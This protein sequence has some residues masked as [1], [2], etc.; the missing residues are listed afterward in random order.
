MRVIP[1][2]LTSFSIILLLSLIAMS[3]SFTNVE[4]VFADRGGIAATPY[5]LEEP[6]QYAVISWYGSVEVLYLTTVVNSPVSTKLIEVLP[7]PSVPKIELGTKKVF[8]GLGS[9][10][11][12]HMSLGVPRGSGVP[13]AGE[14]EIILQKVLG[15]HNITVIKAENYTGF[16]YSL[17]IIAEQNGF[18][19]LDATLEN[20]TLDYCIEDYISR[21][22]NIFAIDIVTIEA[23]D[24]TIAPLVYTF[25]SNKIYYPLKISAATYEGYFRVHLYFITASPLDLEE[26]LETLDIYGY[27][28]SSPSITVRRSKL[29]NLDN[30]L[31]KIFPPWIRFLSVEYVSFGGWYDSELSTMITDIVIDPPKSFDAIFFVVGAIIWAFIIV[32]TALLYRRQIPL[33][34]AYFLIPTV[35]ALGLSI[36]SATNFSL[37]LAN[38]LSTQLLMNTS[39]TV[40]SVVAVLLLFLGY[41]KKPA[42]FEKRVLRYDSRMILFLLIMAVSLVFSYLGYYIYQLI[43]IVLITILLTLP[44]YLVT[45]YGIILGYLSNKVLQLAK[46]LDKMRQEESGD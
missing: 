29:S 27:A 20:I 5:K 3:S 21:G 33:K 43:P 35:V 1:R 24:N 9:I 30:K 32:F 45:V 40:V 4:Y 28:F 37:I 25:R 11:Q 46:Q 42:I 7:L 38:E 2:N 10:V 15:P 17:K 36:F 19:S 13:A 6:G 14:V 12:K 39:A 26:E 8:E 44:I 34:S 23:G 41:T 31:T 22:Y 16:L 18:G